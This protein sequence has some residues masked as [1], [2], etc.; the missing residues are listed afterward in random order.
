M[1][2]LA[3]LTAKKAACNFPNNC[4]P[5]IQIFLANLYIPFTVYLQE[6]QPPYVKVGVGSPGHF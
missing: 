3:K 6:Y 4:F 2:K 5:S 1:I